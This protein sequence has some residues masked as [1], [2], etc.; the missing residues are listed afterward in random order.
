M[1]ILSQNVLENY[2]KKIKRRDQLE[3][4]IEKLERSNNHLKNYVNIYDPLMNMEDRIR[5]NNKLIADKYI[6]IDNIIKE[7]SNIEHII[8][9]L[10]D[11]EKEISKLRF[12][13]KKEYILISREMN[14]SQSTVCRRVKDILLK[15]DK[16][17][18]KIS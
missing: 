11:E 6:E 10:T 2:Y 14:M 9:N 13:K 4:E 3:C 8:S 12:D 7:I 1:K 5:F 15:I 16:A 17:E 18:Q